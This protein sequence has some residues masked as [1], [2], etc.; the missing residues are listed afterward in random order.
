MFF[1]NYG[2]FGSRKTAKD[3]YSLPIGIP[4]GSHHLG[5]GVLSKRHWNFSRNKRKTILEASVTV[6]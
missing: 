1:K 6:F 5:R 2:I 4:R 3:I